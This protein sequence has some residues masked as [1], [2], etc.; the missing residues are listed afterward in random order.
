VTVVGNG[1][2][3]VT[4]GPLKFPSYIGKKR[5]RKFRKEKKVSFKGKHEQR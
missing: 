3:H 5:K 1:P 4:E 2:F